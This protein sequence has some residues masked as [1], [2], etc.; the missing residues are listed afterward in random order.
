M[1]GPGVVG[2]GISQPGAGGGGSG[3]V[4]SVSVASANGFAGTVA[5]PTTTPAIS[6][7]TSITGLLKGNGTAV[8]GAVAGT[9]YSAGTSGLAT[10]LVKSTTGTGA[11]T[12]AVAGTDYIAG[13]LTGDV[14]T[15]GNAATLVGTA[16]VESIIRANTLDQMTAPAANVA[17]NSHK[18]TGLAVGTASG[19]AMAFGL[20]S[21]DQLAAAAGNYAMGT[22]RITGLAAPAATT[23]AAQALGSLLAATYYEP[24][25]G[26]APSIASTTFAAVDTTNLTVTFT[27]ISSAVVVELSAII[28]LFSASGT[29][30]VGFCLFTHGSTTQVGYHTTAMGAAVTTFNASVVAKIRVT[31]LTAGV[32]TQ[33]DWAWA[34]TG[35][36]ALMQIKAVSSGVYA[37]A[38]AGPAMMRVFAA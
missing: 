9:D 24:A 2:P 27:P 30:L 25:G 23:D 20:N 34:V 8:S 12:I 13:P 18:L 11:L 28:N 26:V 16:N 1:P 4:T 5:N 7:Q 10:G 17:M 35:G 36:T 22:H 38:D 37:A 14:T 21:L 29:D 31:G 33:L 15:V 32:S 19:D 3:T 6:V